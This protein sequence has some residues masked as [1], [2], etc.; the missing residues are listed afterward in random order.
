MLASHFLRTESYLKIFLRKMFS[1]D[2]HYAYQ[3]NV[4]N[5]LPSKKGRGQGEGSLFLLHKI[6]DKL[7][8][9]GLR[10]V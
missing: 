1:S 4:I 2:L 3:F 6:A 9:K 10:F 8:D 5:P 7:I